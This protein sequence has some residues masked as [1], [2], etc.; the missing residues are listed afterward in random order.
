MTAGARL[1]DHLQAGRIGERRNHHR[2]PTQQDQR[3]NPLAPIWPTLTNTMPRKI[4][5]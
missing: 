5:A 4:S 1:P 3:P 2:Q